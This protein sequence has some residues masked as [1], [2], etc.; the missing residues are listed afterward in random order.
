MHDNFKIPVGTR[1]SRIKSNVMKRQA[2]KKKWDRHCK[3]EAEEN[4]ATFGASFAL[5]EF[6]ANNDNFIRL[7]DEGVV[8][9]GEGWAYAVIKKGTLKAWYDNLT[10]KFKGTINK[11]HEPA[12][13]LG[14][15]SK[16]DLRL[17]ELG[18]GRYGLDVN[19]KLDDELYAVKDLKRMMNRKAVSS[20]FYYNADEYIT[21]EAATGDEKQGKWLIPL[22]NEISLTGYAVVDNP[23][24]ANSYDDHLL[25]KAGASDEFAANETSERKDM[26][27]EELKAKQAEEAAKAAAEGEEAK[28]AEEAKDD[29][30]KEENAAAGDLGEEATDDADNTDDADAGDAEG[31]GDKSDAEG[32][33]AGEGE[34]DGDDAD[35][36]DK[37][38]KSE[39]NAEKLADAIKSLK[40]ELKAKDEKIAEL[41]AKL[42]D[43]KSKQDKYQND[44]EKLFNFA[45]ADDP[46][47]DEG[48]D[49]TS[50]SED[51]GEKD[52]YEAALDAAFKEMEG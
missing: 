45:T 46:T 28:E 8:V 48:G 10:P 24:N 11:D 23:K 29:E 16:G 17:V 35:A 2:L 1:E 51:K 37:E 32:D 12:I 14:V 43:S 41:K 26:T 19:V 38:E 5:G 27:E 49:T 22:I 50:E 13:D 6:K 52:D 36:E 39:F 4:V 25:E 40:A 31:E 44:L 9:D 30:Q 33:D 18:E 47:E 21:A 34:A 42:S 3:Y 15:F 7:L 20:E